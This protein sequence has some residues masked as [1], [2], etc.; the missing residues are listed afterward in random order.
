M[1]RSN[2]LLSGLIFAYDATWRL[3]TLY[4]SA[5]PFGKLLGVVPTLVAGSLIAVGFVVP[6]YVAWL[7]YC[8][9]NSAAETLRPWCKKR[10]P[11]IYAWVQS[12]YWDVGFLRYWTISNI[13]LFILAAPMLYILAKSAIW[14]LTRRTDSKIIKPGKRNS[15][16]DPSNNPGIRT[17]NGER[18][19][20]I[21]VRLAIPQLAVAVM[22]LTGYHVQII[23]RLASGYPV[24]Y[25][26]LASMMSENR[27]VE[28]FGR[29][30][31]L[32]RVISRWMV[33]YAILQG[34]LFASFLPPA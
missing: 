4:L 27:E 1:V 23:T 13:P 14:G 3:G 25:W 5:Q 28:L 15:K 21:I 31:R 12:H 26:W 17:P 32:A 22:A 10:V 34:G 9:D 30:W 29:K 11:S 16:I 24:W 2:G 19:R 33:L 6:Q 7:E 8:T 18:A 20:Q